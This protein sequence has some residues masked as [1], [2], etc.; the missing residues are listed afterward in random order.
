MEFDVGRTG[1]E[2]QA[3]PGSQAQARWPPEAH[4][5]VARRLDVLTELRARLGPVSLISQQTGSNASLRSLPGP[6][7]ALA[8]LLPMGGVQKG[9]SV[10][11]SGFG[12]WTLAMTFAGWLMESDGWMAGVG[13]EDLGLIGAQEQGVPLDRVL[14]VETPPPAQWATVVAALIE[15]M[16]VV[17]VNPLQPVG[18]L[19]ARRLQARA[20][21]QQAVLVHL[22]GGRTWPYPVDLSLTGRRQRWE[23]LGEGHGHLR[24]RRL[25]I[26][27]GGRRAPGAGQWAELSFGS[28]LEGESVPEGA[29][30]V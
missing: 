12:G 14:M 3:Q 11:V 8:P 28:V 19:D 10:G 5:S 20:R 18:R 2:V 21:E 1:G 24:G 16:Q 7:A 26:E 15:A 17:C 25:L 27:V 29:I 6:I 30:G 4:G 13:L 9:W 23:G 22:D